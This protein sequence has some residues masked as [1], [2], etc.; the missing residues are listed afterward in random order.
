MTGEYD[1]TSN[2]GDQIDDCFKVLVLVLVLVLAVIGSGLIKAVAPVLLF[3]LVGLV[4]V[5]PQPVPL[6]GGKE[7]E[8]RNP[9]ELN[10]ARVPLLRVMLLVVF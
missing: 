6:L 8:L 3:K 1:E 2:A 9:D 5:N 7:G 4:L 10:E